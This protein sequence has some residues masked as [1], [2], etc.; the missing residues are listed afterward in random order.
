MKRKSIASKLAVFLMVSVFASVIISS[1]IITGYLLDWFGKDIHEK[2]MLHI[3]GLSGTVKGFMDLAFSVNYQLSINPEIVN[4]VLEADKNWE[5]RIERYKEGKDLTGGFSDTSGM[6]LLVKMQKMYDFTELFF[7]QD[8]GGDQVARSFGPLGHRSG[9]WWFKEIVADK[10]YK[11][12]ISKSYYSMTGDKL[13]TS[14]FHPIYHD[15]EFIGIMGTDINF[16]KLQ[17]MVQAYLSSSDLKAIVIDNEGVIIAHPEENKLKEMHNLKRLTRNVL[18]K[19]SSGITIQD[20]TGYHKISEEAL[21]WPSEV[22]GLVSRALAGESGFADNINLA[23]MTAT[24]YYD[25]VT[26]PGFRGEK[27]NYAIILIRNNATI[28]DTK[29]VIGMFVFFFTAA[30]LSALFVLF[31]LRF[32]KVVL[33]PLKILTRAMKQAGS[34]QYER[35]SL[36]T[37]DEFDLIADTYNE[38]QEN[39]SAADREMRELNEKLENRVEERT[40]ELKKIN[41]QLKEDIL[42]RTSI[43]NALRESEDRYRKILETAPDAISIN[44]LKNG[45][46]IEVNDTFCQLTGYVREEAL[47]K[48]YS[49]LN[50]FVSPKDL[51]GFQRIL[52]TQKEVRGEE[53]NFRRKDG[54][55]R[56]GLF[57]ARR[58]MYGSEECLISVVTDITRQKQIEE[59]LRESEEKYRLLAENANDAIFIIQE[60][61][62]KFPNPKAESLL[63]EVMETAGVKIS[64]DFFHP[65]DQK[66]VLNRFNNRLAGKTFS[67]NCVFRMICTDGTEKW[68][69][70]NDVYI[71]W[72][73]KPATLNFLRDITVQK[74]LEEQFE[75]SQRMDAVGTLAGGI[76]HN[77]NNL[78]MGIQGNISLISLDKNTMYIHEEEIR[79]IERCIDSGA[80]LT[81][82]LLGFARGGKYNVQSCDDINKIVSG[83]VK[84]FGQ[85]K[86]EI[87]IHGNYQTDIW[88][89]VLD[90]GQVELVLLN[91]YVNAAQAMEGGGDLYLQTENVE[92]PDNQA[93]L[94]DC[95]PGKYV[96]VSITDTGVGMD[97]E[98]MTKIFEPFFTTKSM[99]EGT[100]LGLSSAFGII[101]SHGGFIDVSSRKGHGTRFDIY[102]PA[103]EIKES[104]G[105]SRANSVVK[106]SETILLVDDENMVVQVCKTMLENLGYHVIIARGGRVAIDVFMENMDRI[107]LVILDII[108]P[109][110]DGGKVFDVIRA[111]D[112]NVK[113]LLSSGGSLNEHASD[114][115]A[116]GCNGFVQKPFDMAVLSEMIRKVLDGHPLEVE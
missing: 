101:K 26:L 63:K 82:Q 18:L 69:E 112:P 79:S 57:S 105:M 24:L 87:K 115:L 35:I 64:M 38:M 55:V 10:H 86:K 50:M 80:N 73:G 91:I 111:T 42:R 52:R 56:D 11:S 75:H 19:D 15:N 47:G 22:S 25:P 110:M 16:W 71:H 9:R 62:V 85:S 17:E 48:T 36:N 95:S 29:I 65:D 98:I 104:A 114:I 45:Q 78:L 23:G 92:I 13:V 5:N 3:K 84:M 72:A 90:Q 102:L 37:K 21:D 66:M 54:E 103:S 94:H 113:I 108:M 44:A 93:E 59:A 106:G 67:D 27:R 58:M 96:K 8:A 7:V 60:G 32:R 20:K 34:S 70:L 97:R 109:D 116:R 1:A 100:G 6:P 107:S 4:A 68:M 49:E 61:Q 76:A 43:E 77:F 40:A 14:A 99:G 74:K 81:H 39:L 28:A 2:D 51:E 88:T 46:Y 83:T 30:T 33:E 12:F 41:Q 31:Q 89:V 53:I